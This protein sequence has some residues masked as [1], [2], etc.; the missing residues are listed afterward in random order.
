[1][2]LFNIFKRFDISI[3]KKLQKTAREYDGVTKH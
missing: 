1:M 2:N 3:T